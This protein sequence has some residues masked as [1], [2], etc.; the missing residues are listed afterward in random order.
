MSGNLEA[1]GERNQGEMTLVL[2]QVHGCGLVAAP[3]AGEVGA[4]GAA[5]K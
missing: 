3:G 2:H 4:G 5:R 1:E